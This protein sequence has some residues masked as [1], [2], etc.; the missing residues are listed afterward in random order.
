MPAARGDQAGGIDQ[1]DRT[2]AAKT[3][4]QAAPRAETISRRQY[5]A[6]VRSG[7]MVRYDTPPTHDRDESGEIGKPVE[8]RG[9]TDR[10]ESGRE[11]SAGMD[12]SIL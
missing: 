7:P 4:D 9:G 12:S 2:P 10:V 5:L 8:Q 3:A 11:P 1:P 6:E